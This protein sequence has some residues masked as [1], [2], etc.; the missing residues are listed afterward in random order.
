M[1]GARVDRDPKRAATRLADRGGVTG[2]RREHATGADREHRHAGRAGVG[3]VHVAGARV[4]RDPQWGG[5][6]LADRGGVTGDRR[7][8]ATRADPKHRHAVRAGVGDVHAG[9]AG[10]RGHHHSHRKQDQH[11]SHEQHAPKTRA[12]TPAIT[13][14]PN[15]RGQ[16]TGH[17]TRPPAAC[18]TRPRSEQRSS[19]VGA[20]GQDRLSSWVSRKG[21]EAVARQAAEWVGAMRS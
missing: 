17:A 20:V 6:R 19:A 8:H 16:H 15:A 11:A 21:V 10:A 4:D 18:R 2:D 9:R 7:Q 13:A 14:Q 3:D 12:P 1:A 5:A